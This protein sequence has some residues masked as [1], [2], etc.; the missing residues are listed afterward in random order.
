M[1]E[2]EAR[3]LREENAKRKA[4]AEQKDRRIEE[5]E[6]MLMSALLR[7][8]EGERRLAKESQ[9]SRKPP[10]SDGFT[11][12][13][14][15]RATSNKARGGQAGHRGHTLEIVE[16]PEQVMIHRPSH[17]QEC[18]GELA[19]VTGHV[20]ERRHIHALPIMRLVV[21]EQHVEVIT[22]PQCQHENAGSV[23]SGVQ[24]PAHYGPGVQALA[25]S[26]SP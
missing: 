13:G 2:E 19:G 1:T 7:R 15:K 16:K 8:E 10:S 9:N 23:P 3:Q 25:V 6:G 14:K 20:K 5:L 24:A 12:H 11:R 22:C 21:T 26:F 17:C 4:E 18:H